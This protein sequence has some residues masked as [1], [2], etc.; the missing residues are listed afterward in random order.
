MS[1]SCVIKHDGIA[2]INANTQ[3]S[4][5]DLGF[6]FTNIVLMMLK[7]IFLS[8]TYYHK[9]PNWWEA[10]RCIFIIILIGEEIFYANKSTTKNTQITQEFLRTNVRL[11][12]KFILYI[13]HQEY[14]DNT[15][16]YDGTL[17]IMPIQNNDTHQLKR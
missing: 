2:F 3:N 11:I 15:R 13:Y 8:I 7:D 14:L 9:I 17:K 5:K 12:G 16:V 10:I 6:Q 4:S 1:S